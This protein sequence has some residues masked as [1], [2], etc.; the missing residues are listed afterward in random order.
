MRPEWGRENYL[1]YF[2][3][4][5]MLEQFA[6]RRGSVGKVNIGCNIASSFL[7]EEGIERF[8]PIDSTVPT[9]ALKTKL[10][11]QKYLAHLE[12]EELCHV[13]D[14]ALIEIG[15]F[16]ENQLETIR[17]Q[18]NEMIAMPSEK[19]EGLQ[20]A[21]KQ[22]VQEM[23]ELYIYVGVNFIALK[24]ILLRYDCLIRSLDGPPLGK[25]YILKRRKYARQKD[26]IFEALL[27]RRK[28]KTVAYSIAKQ[29]S[30]QDKE[31][32]KQIRT[33]ISL[34]EKS[35][36]QSE[37]TVKIAMNGKWTL[38][39]SFVRSFIQGSLLSD[40]LIVPSFIRT[41]GKTLNKE[42][43]FFVKWRENLLKTGLEGP[44]VPNMKSE[45]KSYNNA[46]DILTAPLILN[47]ISQMF[48]MIGYYIVEPSSMNYMRALGGEDALAGL[49]IGMTPCF[50]LISAVVYSFWSNNSFREPMLCSGLFLISGS[51][52]YGS[53]LHHRSVTMALTGRALQGLGSPCVLNLRYVADTVKSSNRTAAS[54]I[55]TLVSA[56]GMSLGPGLAVILD[57]IDI[58][59]K[60]PVLGYIEING[61][62]AP[63]FFMAFLWSVYY[64]FLWTRFFDEDRVGLREKDG[65]IERDKSNYNPPTAAALAEK[66]DE[67]FFESFNLE[68]DYVKL[69]FGQST[70]KEDGDN[71]DDLSFSSLPS[72]SSS[73]AVSVQALK[74]RSQGAGS[75]S[76][77]RNNSLLDDEFD[78]RSYD[79]A[80]LDHDQLM[81][82]DPKSESKAV[83][84]RVNEATVICMLLKF[85]G[86]FVME[87]LGCSISII[88]IH[89]YEWEVKNIGTLGF[90]NGCLIIPISML[91]G[92]LSQHY[93]D[94]KLLHALLCVGLLG[95]I[96]LFD[97]SD[98][99][100][101]RTDQYNFDPHYNYWHWAA[102]GPRRYVAGIILEFCGIQA[103][104]SII[105]SMMSKVVPVS[106][107]KGTFNSGFISASLTTL[108]RASGDLFITF[109]GLSSMRLLLNLLA[110]PAMMIM[111]FSIMLSIFHQHQLSV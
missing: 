105:I 86:K 56:L 111:G 44:S 88:T 92:Y 43:L 7:E 103:S 30:K 14:K 20:P 107:A 58:E 72:G 47:F 42:I 17:F 4:K 3:L 35:I 83:V 18:F 100:E 76:V 94:K 11:K 15:H 26:S 95:T 32:G 19:G 90:V 82:E 68:R 52:M 61:M 110:V 29:I 63:G 66:D 24:Q 106:M 41:R 109:M 31:F 48:Y 99:I 91:V 62:S 6:T 59:L 12:K 81:K 60:V 36:Q 27:S 98:V 71:D 108:A 23:F 5:S 80:I 13:L 78:N 67:E 50:A 37:A 85:L 34:M 45:L 70:T 28:L 39:D 2:D 57:F 79:G 104:Q 97:L 46:L 93:S 102:V 55:Y 96:L 73:V 84:E 9:E 21:L 87:I 54:A 75:K 89:R 40:V 25:W 8:Y 10:Q 1:P 101:D 64:Y 51:F 16:Y 38:T 77:D 33:E 53:A 49:L 74:S 65:N 22:L 69:S